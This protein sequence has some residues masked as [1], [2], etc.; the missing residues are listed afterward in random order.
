MAASAAPPSNDQQR[1]WLLLALCVVAAIAYLQRQVPGTV[2][3]AIQID[4]A[5]DKEAMGTVLSAFFF[6]YATLQIPA[7]WICEAWG[8]RRSLI[9]MVSLWAVAS[10][11]AARAQT[12]ETLLVSRLLLG[13]AQAGLFTGT[14]LAIRDRFR[15]EEYGRANGL[16]ATGMQVGGLLGTSLAGE[17]AMA[18]G[19]RWVVAACALPGLPW[20][21]AFL[22][23]DSPP[24][25]PTGTLPPQPDSPLAGLC[26]DE[27]E[28]SPARSS[29]TFLIAP[30]G[31]ARDVDRPGGSQPAAAP[32]TWSGATPASDDQRTPRTAKPQEFGSQL[33]KALTMTWVLVGSWSLWCL[34]T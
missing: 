9:A 13:A 8:V 27:S 20:I 24:R 2:A 1:W 14:T 31:P 32:S 17:L 23:I 25:P 6:S 7:G 16:L 10:L 28:A 11:L 19:W 22:V 34:C 4:L 5:L 29:K 18:W 21:A 30:G 12:P 3:K 26:P 33:A 15:P